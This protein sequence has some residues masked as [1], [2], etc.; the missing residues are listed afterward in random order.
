MEDLNIYCKELSVMNKKMGWIENTRKNLQNQL[1]QLEQKLVSLPD[2]RLGNSDDTYNDGIQRQK[3]FLQNHI[4]SIQ[5]Q[6]NQLNE[7]QQELLQTLYS[8]REKLLSSKA[9]HDTLAAT[10]SQAESGF[11]KIAAQ[12][13]G[14]KAASY[15]SLGAAKKKEANYQQ[16]I[17]I[18]ELIE[19]V[20]QVIA[21]TS[22]LEIPA[23]K[24][25]QDVKIR[26]LPGQGYMPQG[27]QHA[28]SP[29]TDI[30]SHNETSTPVISNMTGTMDMP[31]QTGKTF[32]KGDNK[33]QAS[34][35]H[36][37]CTN[38]EKKN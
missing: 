20:D 2:R 37:F 29:G 33:Y 28:L 8:L 3:E 25:I 9:E 36:D 12:N 31:Q 21:G 17:Q 14:K 26:K 13:F 27:E 38:I 7:E 1:F 34:S 4:T 15:Y 30:G 22:S 10:N 6:M 32:L 23:F 18:K 5:I 19:L 16:S 35:F 24:V 11:A